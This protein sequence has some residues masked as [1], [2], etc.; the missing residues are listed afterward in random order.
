MARKAAIWRLLLSLMLVAVVL[1]PGVA[2]AEDEGT[3]GSVVV[4][5]FFVDIGPKGDVR[6]IERLK[7]V[8]VWL[9]FGP[10]YGC[11][12]AS[13]NARFDG[14]PT[15]EPLVIGVGPGSCPSRFFTTGG[16]ALLYN[17]GG[18]EGRNPFVY[19]EFETFQLGGSGTLGR[20]VTIFEAQAWH[21]VS[22]LSGPGGAPV[23]GIEVR[24]FDLTD[25]G[26]SQFG[27]T[28]EPSEVDAVYHSQSGWVYSYPT[29][30]PWPS[31]QTGI[32]YPYADDPW[33]ITGRMHVLIADFGEGGYGWI[34]VW[35][36]KGGSLGANP[37]IWPG[38]AGW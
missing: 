35:V 24:A 34:H 16:D 3:T 23:D 4:S 29:G 31:G 36:D 20:I 38:R 18:V 6:G 11:T 19:G 12:D 17:V 30:T 5:V 22:T 9:G 27:G 13:G 26:L 37:E 2:A 10:R 8:E 14:V 21:R 28:V 25:P 32:R 33:P 15:G 1:G 7:N